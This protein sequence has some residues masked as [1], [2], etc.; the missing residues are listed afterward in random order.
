MIA[1]ANADGEIAPDE[2]DRIT[3]RLDQAGAGPDERAVLERELLSPRSADQIIREVHD[4]E[5]AEQVYVASRLAMNPD[6][7]AEKAYLDFL[8]A[9]LAIPADRVSELNAAA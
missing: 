1:A 7:P 2:R 4:Q 8:A 9:R 6:T 5:T 3:S